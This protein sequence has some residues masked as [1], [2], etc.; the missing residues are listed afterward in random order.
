MP[1]LSVELCQAHDSLK[2]DII[3]HKRQRERINRYEVTL[4]FIDHSFY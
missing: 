1:T 2:P 3:E 4:Q